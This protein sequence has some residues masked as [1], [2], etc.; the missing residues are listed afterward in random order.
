M[1]DAKSCSF[2]PGKETLAV[3]HEETQAVHY[4]ETRILVQSGEREEE[5]GEAPRLEIL[6]ALVYGGLLESIAG[7]GV[8]SAAAGSSVRTG[9]Q[10][11]IPDRFWFGL[12]LIK[13]VERFLERVIHLM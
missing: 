10:Q 9:K 13:F 12:N 8:I 7:L 11:K 4:E 1:K 2:S 6:K 3:H 5:A